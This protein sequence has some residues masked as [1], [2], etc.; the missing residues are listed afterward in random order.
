MPFWSN[1]IC[2]VLYSPPRRHFLLV[3]SCTQ[4]RASVAFAPTLQ[5]WAPC[6]APPGCPV[7]GVAANRQPSHQGNSRERLIARR[8]LINIQPR[9]RD[10]HG[11]MMCVYCHRPTTPSSGR[12]NA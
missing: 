1:L 5:C 6:F 8:S 9:Y 7:S 3:P 11:V 4:E 10:Q 12:T 2:E